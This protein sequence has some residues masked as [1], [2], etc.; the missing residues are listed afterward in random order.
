MARIAAVTILYHPGKSVADNIL[1][2]SKSVEKVYVIDNTDAIGNNNEQSFLSIPN[3]I[4]FG[5]GRNQG[6]AVRLNLAAEMAIKEGFHFLLTMD[7]DSYFEQSELEKYLTCFQKC[8]DPSIVAMYGVAFNEYVESSK[9]CEAK[10]S[11]D[12]ITSGSILSLSHFKTLG[13]FDEALFIDEVDFEYNYRIRDSGYRSLLYTG[14]RL[15]H[16]LGSSGMYRSLTG[17]KTS[18]SLHS[19]LRMYYMVRNFFYVNRKYGS[20]FAEHKRKRTR[21]LINR[22]KNN[23]IYNNKRLQVLRMAFRGYFD[24]LATKTGKINSN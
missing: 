24:Y 15:E 8:E 17:A 3:A 10:E 14:I 1:S 22:L 9:G 16:S 5:D 2:Y 11:L 7:Q 19:P 21:S 18:R 6:I 12:L 20:G 23:L 13:G 4:Y